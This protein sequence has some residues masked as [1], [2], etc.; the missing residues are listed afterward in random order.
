M[1]SKKVKNVCTKLKINGELLPCNIVSVDGFKTLLIGLAVD[2]F[3]D[4]EE[5]Y[6]VLSEDHEDWGAFWC[7]PKEEINLEY[8]ENFGWCVEDAI[9]EDC[10]DVEDTEDTEEEY[11]YK[12][13]KYEQFTTNLAEYILYNKRAGFC[14]FKLWQECQNFIEA[15]DY[16]TRLDNKVC[17]VEWFGT[18]WCAWFE[19]VLDESF[20]YMNITG[21]VLESFNELCN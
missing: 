10:E 13:G 12:I 11:C 8:D 21:M 18:Y 1:C 9:S 2:P 14:D 5:K 15:E 6:W 16:D 7:I 19:S 4:D 3:M 20:K 17:L